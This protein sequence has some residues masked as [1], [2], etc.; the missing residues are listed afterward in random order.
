MILR[1]CA[2]DLSGFYT[3][4]ATFMNPDGQHLDWRDLYSF[5][6][7]K[8]MIIVFSFLL[9]FWIG[10]VF[11][12]RRKF[13]LI[14][15]YCG[16][17]NLLYVMFL[18]IHGVYLDRAQ[19]TDNVMLYFILRL[20]FEVLYSVILFA[21]LLVASNGWG[22]LNITI[23]WKDVIKSVIIVICVVVPSFL[24]VHSRLGNLLV[25][26]LLIQIVATLCFWHTLYSNNERAKQSIKAHLLAIRNSGILPASTPVYQKLFLYEVSL[27]VTTGVFF[28]LLTLNLFLVLLH[29]Q[30][31]VVGLTNNIVQL[32][33]VIALMLLYRPRGNIIDDFLQPDVEGNGQQRGE[34]ALEELDTF[35]VE[36][37]GQGMMEWE[38]GVNLPLQP[39]VV[40]S[41]SQ[42]SVGEAQAFYEMGSL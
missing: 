19:H 11:M 15:I 31:W 42:A 13:V 1:H 18:I 16:L 4:N 34:I 40:S 30:R 14:H 38:E 39:L 33:T 2:S 20:F 24:E 10:Y 36:E 8:I 9:L 26:V 32:M 6:I 35:E 37:G 12:K 21:T 27:Y 29:A 28:V 17:I 5:S 22:L 3:F 41:K 25:V 7:V 23:L